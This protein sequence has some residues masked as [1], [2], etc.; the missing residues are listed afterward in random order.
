MISALTIFVVFLAVIASAT[1]SYSQI[2]PATTVPPQGIRSKEVFLTCY[3]NCT[4]VPNAKERIDSGMIVINN[5]S[6]VA[7]GKNLAIP[8]GATVVDLRGAWVYPGFIEPYADAKNFGGKEV[9]AG[10]DEVP[11][12]PPAKGAEHW[13]QAVKPQFRTASI[14]D[15]PE[16]TRQKMTESGYTAAAVL[17]RDGILRGTS[18]SVL[19]GEGTPA[20]NIVASD[21]YMGVSQRKGSSST[22]YPS[23]LMGCLALVR[24]VLADSRWYTLARS[25]AK[26]T[27]E[28]NIALQALAE[29]LSGSKPFVVECSDEHDAARWREVFQSAAVA[30]QLLIMRASGYEYRRLP[31]TL[32]TTIVPLAMP[33]PPSSI[34]S[35]GIHTA[36]LA[37]LIHWYW[38]PTNAAAL[39]KG[40]ATIAFTSDGLS[41][42]AEMLRHVR[43]CVERGLDTTA[44]LAA[45][46]SVPASLCGIAN[47]A[48]TIEPGKLANFTITSASIFHEQCTIARTVVAGKT[49]FHEATHPVD[50]RGHWT[51]LI[52]STS[53]SIAIKGTAA[54]PTIVANAD[55]ASL[56]ATVAVHDGTAVITVVRGAET[57]RIATFADSVLM[58]GVGAGVA[59]VTMRRDSAF[60]PSAAVPTKARNYRPQPSIQP[61]GAFGLES[62]PEQLNVVLKNATVWTADSGMVLQN[63]DVL[64]RGGII[65]AVGK[66]LT[67]DSVIDC[68]GKHITPGIID[69]HSHI[70][71]AR[72]VNEGTHAV[73]T[74]V[75]I[76]D[77]VDPD[78]V[79][80][81]RQLAG[82]VVASHL[83]H[84]SANPMGGQLQYIKLRWGANASQLK[85][86]TTPTIKFALG[87]N[88]KQSNWGDAF[89]ARYPQ[90]RMGVEEIMRDAFIAAREYQTLLRTPGVHRKDYQMEAL[91]EILEGKRYIHCHSYVQS[92]ILMLM[93]LAEE[94]GFSVH[95]FTHILE[96][97]KVAKEMRQHGA[98]ASSF[99][100]WW[101][102][103][104]EVYDAIPESPAIMHEQG[105]LTSIN[106]DDAEMAR[107]LNQEAAKST[108]YGAVADTTALTFCTIN[109]AHQ[110]D[111]ASSTGSIR[112][113]KSGDV[114]VWSGN[115]LLTTSRVERTFVDGCQ[116]FSL[117]QDRLLRIRDAELRAFLE[118][119]VLTAIAG[120]ADA[121]GPPSAPRKEYHCE[122]VHDELLDAR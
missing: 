77:V 20:S 102:Y 94:F 98:R 103:K 88:V 6:I 19:L 18:T 10:N 83:L 112:S 32:G 44:A 38:A 108:R 57:I 59:P 8:A 33:K 60:L 37:D 46:T 79:N 27:A 2:T 1:P 4:V 76:G 90:T 11:T 118:R 56:P 68:T 115:P 67:A 66:G 93:R 54:A 62:K 17:R 55:G 21:A 3:V 92:E 72:G 64:M 69:E 35:F 86:P 80:I 48:G 101:A 117:E 22:P 111:V 50:I 30:D 65:V 15:I 36:S 5:G 28:A 34:T 99:A 40:G 95:T 78:D 29:Y 106:S 51:L 58:R 110:M 73:T 52:D 97:Y 14:L 119:E 26:T 16:S 82:G 121:T 45:L 109:A 81:Y 113:G 42:S 91:V 41:N 24:Q 100:D 39:V 71:I 63:A 107:R 96:G 49:V 89:T 53:V 85:E 43:T 61:L 87:E 114:V 84:G 120:G 105:V 23:S 74:E 31:S 122:D 104:F 47:I 25:S 70:A 12:T 13:N 9:P 75:R 116:Y 7:V